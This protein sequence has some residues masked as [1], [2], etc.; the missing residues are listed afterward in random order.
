MRIFY[1][2]RFLEHKQVPGHP[3]CPERLEAILEYL[4]GSDLKYEIAEPES[5]DEKE[6]LAIHTEEHIGRVKQL[7]DEEVILPDNRFSRKTFEAAK[8]AAG[9]SW[10]AAEHA[11]KER[12][13]AFALVRPPGH[14]AGRDFFGGFCYFNNLAFAVR[15]CAKRTLIIDIDVHFGNGTQDIFYDDEKVFYLSL[16]QDTSTIFPGTRFDREDNEHVRNVPLPPG[17]G[18]TEYLEAFEVSLEKVREF[19]P[20]LVAISM[21]FDTSAHCPVA[22]MGIEKSSTYLEFG[23]MIDRFRCPKFACLEGGY[24]LPELGKNT[25]SFLKAFG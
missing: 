14:H 13:F 19:K 10:Q 15:K 24:H 25:Y 20:E 8:L 9:A 17:T 11:L 22:S 12:E 23:R 16:H 4:R 6:L 3:E 7:C 18:D 2:P 21:G 1:S 5:I